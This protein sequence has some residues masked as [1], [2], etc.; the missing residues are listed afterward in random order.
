MKILISKNRKKVKKE[1]KAANNLISKS[2]SASFL[3]KKKEGKQNEKIS[4]SLIDRCHSTVHS[5]L[6]SQQNYAS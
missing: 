2:L 6:R 4:S 5:I 3:Q 1:V